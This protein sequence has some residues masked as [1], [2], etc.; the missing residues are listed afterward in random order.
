LNTF[1]IVL[2]YNLGSKSYS[3]SFANFFNSPLDPAIFYA[4]FNFSK[5]S[6]FFSDFN[7]ASSYNFLSFSNSFLYLSISLVS[8]LL[9][10]FSLILTESSTFL[11]CVVIYSDYF[12]SSNLKLYLYS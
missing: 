11:A 5:I 3:N 8:F 10:A 4:Y 6:F 1:S 7:I 12:P 2:S 9:S